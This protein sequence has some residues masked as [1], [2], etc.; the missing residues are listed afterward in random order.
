MLL[1][2]KRTT[3]SVH[4]MLIGGKWETEADTI[5]HASRTD[6][7][8]TIGAAQPAFGGFADLSLSSPLLIS[9]T[10]EGSLPHTRMPYLTN[11]TFPQN[12]W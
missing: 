11:D 12:L 6:L 5:P 8:R 7:E 3:P 4:G 1:T 2:E 10:G 9:G